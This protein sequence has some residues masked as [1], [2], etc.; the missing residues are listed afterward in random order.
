MDPYRTI[1]SAFYP[2]SLSTVV[3]LR[4]RHRRI[5]GWDWFAGGIMGSVIGDTL[6]IA[7]D[8]GN[9]GRHLFASDT[10]QRS[11]IRVATCDSVPRAGGCRPGNPLE[12]SQ[13]R[14]LASWPSWRALCL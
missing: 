11:R 13:L 1:N 10:G 6:G 8:R 5:S 14:P 9:G 2:F 3:S 4:D 12:Q 7:L